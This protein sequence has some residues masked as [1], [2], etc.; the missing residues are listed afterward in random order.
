MRPPELVVHASSSA[1][2]PPA[3]GRPIAVPIARAVRGWSPVTMLTRTP[4][5]W[6]AAIASWTPGR[7]GS[8]IACRPSRR[9][10]PSPRSIESRRRAAANTS[11]RRPSAAWRRSRAA[12]PSASRQQRQHRLGRALDVE[13][14]ADAAWPSAWAR[15]RTA[16]RR[17]AGARPARPS[18]SS[19]RRARA[20]P[21]PWD[22]RAR[23]WA[24]LHSTPASSSSRSSPAGVH[25]RLDP[26]PVLGQRAGLVGRDDG[27]AAERLD[28]RQV[29]DDRPPARHPPDTRPPARS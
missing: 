15:R 24:S 3:V 20:A 26:H 29:A 10:P 9:R 27:R 5:A 28:R 17:A 14:A 1:P 6:Q 2:S 21:S 8:T 7:G 4:A 25:T 12:A 19:P 13:H 16:A 11:T 18:T 22:R 23:R